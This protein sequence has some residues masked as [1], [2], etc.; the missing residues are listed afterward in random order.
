M[1][2]AGD[3]RRRLEKQ[4]VGFFPEFSGVRSVKIPSGKCRT[5]SLVGTVACHTGWDDS[6][7]L[8]HRRDQLWN[9][10][11]RDGMLSGMF[12]RQVRFLLQ[13]DNT[14]RIPPFVLLTWLVLLADA[15]A[16]TAK[17]SQDAAV[18]AIRK[19]GGTF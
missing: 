18:A 5:N 8:R 3:V 9:G 14:M 2:E 17:E 15:Q 19:L 7:H 13:I 10:A 11:R 6:R 16:Q 12:L 1:A 4:L